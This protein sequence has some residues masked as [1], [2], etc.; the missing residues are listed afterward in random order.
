VVGPSLVRVSNVT[1]LTLLRP[2]AE[3]NHNSI[4]VFAVFAEID[5]ISWPEIDAVLEHAGTGALDVREVP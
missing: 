5:P 2:A 3:Q 4:G 1:V